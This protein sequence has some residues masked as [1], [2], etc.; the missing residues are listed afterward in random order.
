M[1]GVQ[2]TKM[3]EPQR[4][5]SCNVEEDDI[6]R[7]VEK[8][9]EDMDKQ[10][11]AKEE[12]KSLFKRAYATI[13]KFE[14]KEDILRNCN[15]QKEN[16]STVALHSHQRIPESQGESLISTY[17]IANG[18]DG[19]EINIK[20]LLSTEMKDEISN[21][22]SQMKDLCTLLPIATFD[23]LKNT[24]MLP[25]ERKKMK[26]S[27][28][29]QTNDNF[30]DF[31]AKKDVEID[32][33]SNL[34]N[35]GDAEETVKGQHQ[36]LFKPSPIIQLSSH[37]KGK[38]ELN[39]NKSKRKCHGKA[40]NVKFPILPPLL[41]LGMYDEINSSLHDK[42]ED[43][44]S[45]KLV[46]KYHEG[47]LIYEKGQAQHQ[48][49][50][51]PNDGTKRSNDK[52][53]EYESGKYDEFISCMESNIL[54]KMGFANMQYA[55][56]KKLDLD[57]QKDS[58]ND[59]WNGM[60]KRVDKD[61]NASPNE[62]HGK[63]II[64][65]KNRGW[66]EHDLPKQKEEMHNNDC[67]SLK[68]YCTQNR[69]DELKTID[70]QSLISPLNRNTSPDSSFDKTSN[71]VNDIVRRIDVRDDDI[72]KRRALEGTC[73]NSPDDISQTSDKKTLC[74]IDEMCNRNEYPLQNKFVVNSQDQK[75]SSEEIDQ[76][77][78]NSEMKKESNL[79]NVN[80][81]RNDYKFSQSQNNKDKILELRTVNKAKNHAEADCPVKMNVLSCDFKSELINLNDIKTVYEN[82]NNK[83]PIS[84][85]H[86]LNNTNELDMMSIE[87]SSILSSSKL[88]E[89]ERSKPN[90][91]KNVEHFQSSVSRVPVK[92]TFNSKNINSGKE[93]NLNNSDLAENKQNNTK[94]ES[95]HKKEF[96]K[97]EYSDSDD[98][99]TYSKS[100][101]QSN[102]KENT[103]RRFQQQ[104][105][106]SSTLS[107]DQLQ[108]VLTT[109]LKTIPDEFETGKNEYSD[110]SIT[111]SVANLATIET[112]HSFSLNEKCNLVFSNAHTSI[113]CTDEGYENE[114]MDN[115]LHEMRSNKM[116]LRQENISESPDS[117]DKINDNAYDPLCPSLEF[118]YCNDDTN[119]QKPTRRNHDAIN[120]AK[121]SFNSNNSL[122]SLNLP[123]TSVYIESKEHYLQ[124]SVYNRTDHFS[125]QRNSSQN[126]KKWSCQSTENK[127]IELTKKVD[128]KSFVLNKMENKNS[129]FV[130][131][132]YSGTE[133]QNW[134]SKDMNNSISQHSLSM[135]FDMR[136]RL[137]KNE[138]PVHVNE[139]NYGRRHG[140]SPVGLFGEPHQSFSERRTFARYPT[141]ISLEDIQEVKSQDEKSSYTDARNNYN[142]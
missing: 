92:M 56:R 104:Q 116:I 8:E 79:D 25:N 58:F 83:L 40:T 48:I 80:E 30:N 140:T 84:S 108:I 117:Y 51:G 26:N 16:Q 97:P 111:S 14:D 125:L 109:G 61:Y 68:P 95:M 23:N 87:T 59:H 91:A 46:I 110:N 131:K 136:N 5:L 94:E 142:S 18:R 50:A 71:K 4:K 90:K 103:P 113:E 57:L 55:I 6:N 2:D 96:E 118:E 62:T 36:I 70:P 54:D 11:D 64:S 17:N 76:S 12:S 123:F 45:S 41:S 37:D 105:D 3:H 19:A 43:K 38:K 31:Q 69:D 15:L 122:S 120:L 102:L 100:E 101:M 127:K 42:Q 137:I 32:V 86:D 74:D 67:F 130:Q 28:Q 29:F 107:S 81:K 133:T 22:F 124:D 139:I 121:E 60:S 112:K 115:Y 88:E 27:K 10:D 13:E 85:C 20:T 53:Q 98:I 49:S 66:K 9:D 52:Q 65:K 119:I 141:I 129:L 21:D 34:L 138:E 99:S 89:K 7:Q 134:P 106:T 128:K 72:H 82:S 1:N 35:V 114:R 75:T 39:R 93:K 77:K 132:R 33:L 135:R 44:T 126:S 24:S 63:H 47:S 73:A 78:S